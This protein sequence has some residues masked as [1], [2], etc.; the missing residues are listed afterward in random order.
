MAVRVRAVGT[1]EPSSTVEVR[2]QVSGELLTVGFAEGQD[3]K[4]GQ[5]L[6]TI[7]PRPF[8]AAVRQAEATLARDTAL[9]KNADAQ[10]VR[11]A[12]LAQKGLV[13]RAE[14][15]AVIAASASLQ[16]TL[17]SD[18]AQ[19]ETAK[20]Q[21]QYTKITAPVS[22]R[23]GALLVHKGSLV[24]ANDAAPLV[25]INEIAPVFVSFA[26]AARLLPDLRAEQAKAPIAVQ[27]AAPEAPDN[28]ADGDVTFIDNAVDPASDTIRLKARFDNRDRRLW[29]GVFVDV[30]LRMSVRPH[31]IV[32]PTRAVQPGQ[33]GSFVYVVKEDQ[34][35]E[36][37][38][39]VT[40][41]VDGAETVIDRGVQPGEVV[42]TDGH[43]RLVPGMK[44]V[45]KPENGAGRSGS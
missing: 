39:V 7:D 2:P 34:T 31:A 45:V 27:A 41:W 17:A 26:V 21:L 42:V 37:R 29:P 23:T 9:A 12:D 24:R 44:I 1:V 28:A 25:V 10:R 11:Y 30:T 14:Y 15:D 40:A 36:A 6:F 13:S 43:L 16:A 3:V 19:L 33:Q 4:T 8:E 18:A 32:V 20:L 38:Q 35:V 5:V 22:G